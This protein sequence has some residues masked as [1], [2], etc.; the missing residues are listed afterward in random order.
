MLRRVTASIQAGAFA[1]LSVGVF[2]LCLDIA[3][4]D[5]SPDERIRLAVK[6]SDVGVAPTLDDESI[7]PANPDQRR[8]ARATISST[9]CIRT[10]GGARS[11]HK[12]VAI[13]QPG[14]LPEFLVPK[15]VNPRAVRAV[16]H[17][18]LAVAMPRLRSPPSSS[19]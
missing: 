2:F 12:T 16:A 1:L 18:P 19:L 17:Q 15:S 6:A 7:E 3:T 5:S 4:T 9:D 11:P 13:V 8:V 10:A 14:W